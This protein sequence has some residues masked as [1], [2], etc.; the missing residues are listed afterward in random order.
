M[1]IV[2]AKRWYRWNWLGGL[3]TGNDGGDRILRVAMVCLVE[4]RGARRNDGLRGGSFG[5]SCTFCMAD[6]AGSRRSSFLAGLAFLLF[7]VDWGRANGGIGVF[8]G[9]E[10]VETLYQLIV[11]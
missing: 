8:D 9:L 7:A 4:Y 6:G 10:A 11:T 5:W 1:G 3:L 2:S